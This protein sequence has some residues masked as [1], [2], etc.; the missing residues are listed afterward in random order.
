MY[1]LEQSSELLLLQGKAERIG[2]VGSEY[3]SF[4]LAAEKIFG[5]V[6]EFCNASSLVID[7]IGC[8]VVHGGEKFVKPQVVDRNI[9][10]QIRELKSLAPIHNEIAADVL[11]STLNQFVS[12][13]IIAV[14][15]TSFHHQLPDVAAKYA[16]PKELSAKFHLRRYGFH[17]IAHQ[18]VSSEIIKCLAREVEGSRVISCHLGNGASIAAIKDGKCIDTS[19]GLTPLEGLI[20]GT[21]AGDIDP[22]LILHL[23]NHYE[24]DPL[25]LEQILNFESGLLGLSALSADVRDLEIAASNNQDAEFALES[26]AY[27]VAKYIG[28]YFVALGGVDAITFSG[29]IAENS[30]LMRQRICRKISSLGITIS[31]EVNLKAIAPYCISE[32]DSFVSAWVVHADE[33]L[34]IA[35]EL[36]CMNLKY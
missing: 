5:Q 31:N 6:Q 12:S 20:M 26:F 34:Q 15:D 25:E 11:E 30:N 9:I 18:Y 1:R 14:F 8:R 21:R 19:M 16:L 36:S 2:S 4:K 13:R 28:S 23:I 7:I 22:G 32:K 29:G 33:N 24:I 27:R 10:A 17:G 35:R 3:S